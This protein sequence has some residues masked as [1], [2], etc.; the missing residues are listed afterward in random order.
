MASADKTD[1]K[2][3]QMADPENQ[4]IDKTEMMAIQAKNRMNQWASNTLDDPNLLTKIRKGLVAQHSVYRH[5][6]RD[7]NKSVEKTDI[8]FMNRT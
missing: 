6:F 2:D 5:E 4:E 8:P 7:R 1:D 3:Q